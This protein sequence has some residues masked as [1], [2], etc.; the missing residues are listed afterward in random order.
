MWFELASIGIGLGLLTFAY[1]E[2]VRK[3]NPKD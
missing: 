1:L 3:Q 2:Y